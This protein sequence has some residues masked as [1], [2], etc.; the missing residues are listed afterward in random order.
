MEENKKI[1]YKDFI[2]REIEEKDNK[3]IENVI[4]AC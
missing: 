1:V 4:R 3:D 2:I